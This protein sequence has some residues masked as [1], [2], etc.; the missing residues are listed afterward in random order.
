MN[1]YLLDRLG[2]VLASATV[3]GIDYVEVSPSQT[4][5]KVHFLNSVAL[6]G[7][8]TTAKITGGETISEVKVPNLTAANW[9]LLN[10]RP[11]LTFSVTSPG[12]FSIYT[13]TVTNSGLDPYFAE[14]RF[15][16]KA[17]CP[18]D[19]DCKP[20]ETECP[21]DDPDLPLID[22][23]AKDFLS[24]RQALMDFSAQRY[25]DWKE[26]SEADFGMMF[27]EA[28]SGLADDLSYYQD[29][30]AQESMIETATERRSVVRLARLVDYEPKPAVAAHALLQL[31]VKNATTSIPGGLG[32][33]A[34]TAEG[35]KLYFETGNGLLDPKS[36]KLAKESFSVNA[37][38][39]RGKLVPYI[40]DKSQAC[41][42]A[43]STEMWIEGHGHSLGTGVELL[44][45]T[46]AFS[47]A[48]APVRETITLTNAVEET[49]PVFLTAGN[50]T[51]VTHLTWATPLVFDHALFWTPDEAKDH[52][53][54]PHRTILAG[55]LVPSTHGQTQ[56][57]HFATAT[58]A[59]KLPLGAPKGTT[60][61][62]V[63]TGPNDSPEA[64]TPLYLHTLSQ[65]PLAWLLRSDTAGTQ[66]MPHPEIVLEQ[67][68]KGTLPEWSWLR[69]LLNA[70][71]F[72]NAFA[73]DPAKYVKITDNSD[74]SASYEYD[75]DEGDTIR[76]G[77][78]VFGEMPDQ[79]AIFKVTFRVG[80]TAAGN[81]ARDSILGLST[82]A[83]ALADSVTNPFAA[84]DGAD[85]ETDAAVRRD[86]PQAFRASQFRAVR[87][88]DYEKA[89]ETL[90][91]VQRAGTRF[92]WTGSWL[93]V[94]T[95]ADP[96]D[97]QEIPITRH[98][99]LV[100]LLNRY[101]MAGYESYAPAPKY[102]SLDF[103][104]TVCACNDAYRGDTHEALLRTLSSRRFVDGTVGFFHPDNLTFGQP[105]ER[106]VL[107]AAIEGSYGVCGVLSIQYRRRG[108]TSDFVEMPQT[109][110]VGSFEILQVNNDPSKPEQ[111][112]LK[113]YVEGGK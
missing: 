110:F 39:N 63:R 51:P 74:G 75:G 4:T 56:V 109:V 95:S 30:I 112:S 82:A 41:L 87:R 15:S 8:L 49:D 50:P 65:S 29:R 18:S 52:N 70:E 37:K 1:N 79:G 108:F 61:A 59:G 84:T 106:S 89:A 103:R 32:F 25:P 57:E 96:K 14:S 28:L 97:A 7:N 71:L 73:I 2:A 45:D 67:L 92:R 98:L 12:D 68:G 88:E 47:S 85:P 62:V 93:T 35:Y 111:G 26:R 58:A 19:L 6:S 102:V 20:P 90:P 64:P 44:I 69:S 113:I 80:G 34:T 86:A 40:W 13:L 66:T 104:I 76:F 60:L 78:G 33:T 101:R 94:F 21:V 36:G 48:D 9:S 55:N 43:G 11:L 105:L 3:N 38:W 17:N 23:L 16:F 72:Q 42:L 10:G 54:Q 27:L 31:D 81:V 46:P 24:F 91:W 99:E 107:E 100:N 5:L 77:D 53:N 22:Y 83:L